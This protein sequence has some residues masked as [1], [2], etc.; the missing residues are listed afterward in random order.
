MIPALDQGAIA[1]S[2]DDEACQSLKARGNPQIA[3]WLAWK[4]PF[5][6]QQWGITV[7]NAVALKLAPRTSLP[8]TKAREDQPRTNT[9]LR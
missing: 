6:A 3:Q 8:R 2:T 5:R 7:G 1:P 4:R 9:Q